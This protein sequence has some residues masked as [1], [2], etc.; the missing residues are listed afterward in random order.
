VRLARVDDNCRRAKITN[1]LRIIYEKNYA[2]DSDPVERIL[3]EESLVPTSVSLHF[4]P[5]M[6][7]KRISL[8]ALQN[9]FSDRLSAFGFNL[10]L[11]LLVDLLHE[12]ELG[13]WRAIFIHLIRLLECAGKDLVNEMDRR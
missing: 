4:A 10:F 9:A 7:I 13:V 8:V 1:A 5:V 3:K 2:V 12:F 11:M 6:F